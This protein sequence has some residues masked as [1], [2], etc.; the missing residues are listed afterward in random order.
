MSISF[1]SLCTRAALAL[2]LLPAL[3]GAATPAAV[4]GS[5]DI[6]AAAQKLL[7]QR[8]RAD[9]ASPQITVAALDPRLRL[10][11]CEEP[12]RASI[13]GDGQLH[14][15]TTVAV[16]CETP[17]RW[18]IYLRATVNTQLK[19]L[20]ARRQLPRGTEITAA[21]FELGPRLVAGTGSD[22]L[23]SFDQLPG[24]RLRLPLESGAVLTIDK[25]EQAPVVHRGQTVTLLAKGVGLEIRVAA[26]ALADGSPQ[27]RIAV[28]NQSTH[29]VVQ[30]VVR[31]A[32]LVE[33]EL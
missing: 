9:G 28:Q 6:R 20:T 15:V 27:Q 29:Q 14:A 30:A 17:V 5:D 19:V 31:D 24:R 3:L 7:E 22:A 11:H 13:A 4:S 12:L 8:S 25:V 33:V 16:R 32:S 10:S 2:T 23:R 1:L 21:D 26:V 18:S